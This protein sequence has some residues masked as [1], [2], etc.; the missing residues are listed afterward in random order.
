MDAIFYGKGICLEVPEYVIITETCPVTMCIHGSTGVVQYAELYQNGELIYTL[1]KDDFAEG[2]VTVDSLPLYG[3]AEFKFKVYYTSGATHEEV[4][5]VKCYMPIFIGLL[6]KW[7]FA[8]TV[9][10]DYLIELCKEDTEGTQNRFLNYKEDYVA[11][12]K[13]GYGKDLKSVTFKYSFVDPKL[14]HPF[15][16][17]PKDYSDLKSISINSQQFNLAAFDVIDQIPM[18]VPGVD[19]DMV[20]KIYV[21]RQA[22]SRLDSEVTFNF[23]PRNE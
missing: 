7:K 16:V 12:P 20:Y 3:D 8:N 9:T 5:L 15:I 13:E 14:R 6:P 23:T 10:F 11:E 19:H 17:L 1:Q 2:C 18:Q 4:R 21:Y 22:L